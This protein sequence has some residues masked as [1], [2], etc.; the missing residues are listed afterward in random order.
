MDDDEKKFL[1]EVRR[2]PGPAIRLKL[3]NAMRKKCLISYCDSVLS[4][5]EWR[6]GGNG[7]VYLSKGNIAGRP[8]LLHRIVLTAP[9][10]MNVHHI[11]GIKTDCRRENLELLTP[12]EHNKK[13]AKSIIRRNRKKRIYPTHG[14]CPWCKKRFKKHPDHRG[15]QTMCGKD[16]SMK[17]AR[18]V[19][20]Q[21]IADALI[22]RLGE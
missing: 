1:S 19:R 8:I 20:K 5:S 13:H 9:G 12:S 11:N 14:D 17:K 4:M 3:K 7:Y 10:G 18:L 15:R 6:L 16:C 22:K 21:N 2:G